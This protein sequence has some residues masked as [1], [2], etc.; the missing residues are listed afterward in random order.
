[1]R[2]GLIFALAPLL[3]FAQQQP[4]AVLGTVKSG[5]PITIDGT[6]FSPAASPS[7]PVADR[8]ELAVSSASVLFAG[9]DGNRLT[10]AP[11]TR[12]L[13]RTVAG[14][15]LYFYVRQGSLEFESTARGVYVCIGNRLFVSSAQAK[16]TMSLGQANAVTRQTESGRLLEDGVRSCGEQGITGFQTGLTPGTQGAAGGTATGAA[17]PAAGGG[18]STPGTIVAGGVGVGVA[19]SS[20]LGTGVSGGCGTPGGCNFNPVAIS[21]SQPGQ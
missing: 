6:S 14:G 19:V 3:A 1:M 11:E 2:L 18:I 15:Q 13:V 5:A 7:W 12:V 9:V 4:G 8:D 17:A 16:G 10:F 21:P 20:G